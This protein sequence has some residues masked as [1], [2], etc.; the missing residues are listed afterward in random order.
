M[1]TDKY[2]TAIFFNVS[3]AFEKVWHDRLLYKIKNCF[4]SDLYAVI[5]PYLLY[6][7]FIIKYGK[8][9]TQL[10][11]INFGIPQDSVLGSVFYLL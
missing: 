5:K 11:D 10:K 6:R 4:P 2:C 9:I 1:E 3:Q 8:V 7:I